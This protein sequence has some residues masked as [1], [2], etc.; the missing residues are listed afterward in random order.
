MNHRR[1]QRYA[2]KPVLRMK[3]RTPWLVW[4][5]RRSATRDVD[6][7]TP[8]ST[9]A[10]ICMLSPP[11]VMVFRGLIAAS[12]PNL[13]SPLPT[14]SLLFAG[15]RFRFRIALTISSGSSCWRSS[16]WTS[17]EPIFSMTSMTAA[18]TTDA[19]SAGSLDIAFMSTS[20]R[21][22]LHP[23]GHISSV[24]LDVLDFRGPW[25]EDRSQQP[26]DAAWQLVPS[27]H[28]RRAPGVVCTPTVPP[29]PPGSACSI[30][31][32]PSPRPGYP[33]GVSSLGPALP[34]V[35]TEGSSFCLTTSDV[36]RPLYH[37]S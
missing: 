2:G 30:L 31:D 1:P 35:G 18:P 32:Y 29:A 13:E 23:V 25:T 17:T 34:R 20:P 12:S 14:P 21:R 33:L 15:A 22:R 7:Q 26:G 16:W 3:S 24:N 9:A 4:K 8:P 36:P 6:N 19:T 28:L 10:A 11:S 37:P 27:S 5:P